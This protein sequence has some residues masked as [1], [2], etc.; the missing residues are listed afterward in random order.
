MEDKAGF[1]RQ[2]LHAA[3]SNDIS[4][5]KLAEETLLRIE[6]QDPDL[7][8]LIASVPF[9]SHLLPASSVFVLCVCLLVADHRL[10]DRC[11]RPYKRRRGT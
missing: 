1:V 9:I 4:Q 11:R 10:P 7:G 5:I 8:P 6:S 2:L 3:A